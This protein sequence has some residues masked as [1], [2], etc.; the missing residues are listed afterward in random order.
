[1][2]ASTI[3]KAVMAEVNRRIQEGEKAYA[4]H[5][6]EVEARLAETIRTETEKAETSKQFKASQIVATILG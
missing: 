3:K 2:F 5:V 4:E 6:A 1:M